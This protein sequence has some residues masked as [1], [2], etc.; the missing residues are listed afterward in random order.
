L[1]S[2]V[3]HEINTE[4]QA[5]ALLVHKTSLLY[6]GPVVSY[7]RQQM[8]LALRYE[9]LYEEC[10]DVAS[11][12]LRPK[13]LAF[14]IG[15]GFPRFQRRNGC[16]YVFI[17]FS[18]LRKLRWWLPIPPSAS[19]WIRQKR[20]QFLEKQDLYDMIL[21]F[22]P[23]QTRLLQES[24]PDEVSVRHFMT[25]ALTSDEGTDRIP[26]RFRKW[27]VCFIG[28]DSPRR[29]RIRKTL[30]SRGMIVSPNTT[31][32]LGEVIRQSRLV[33]NVHFVRCDTLE[34]PRI[35]HSLSLGACLVTERCYGLGGVAP[36]NCYVSVPYRQVAVTIERLLKSPATIET[37]GAM[38]VNYMK[39]DY[40]RRAQD[41]WSALVFEGL[42][43]F[44]SR[45]IPA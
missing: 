9:P 42:S 2:P 26:L 33:A 30:Q 4:R 10:V 11:V 45:H 3:G 18:L 7:I 17:N 27:D 16:R 15:D 14:I 12:G 29:H 22:H 19:R 23:V 40:A 8:T 36:S 32:N 38:A 44:Q 20:R 1:H 6:L 25:G 28:T 43:L 31:N 35:V 5:V 24:G 39:S 37:I 41:S 13:T 34:A 21:D